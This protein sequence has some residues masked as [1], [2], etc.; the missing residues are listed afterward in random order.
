MLT[1]YHSHGTTVKYPLTSHQNAELCSVNLEP[2][3]IFVCSQTKFMGTG[4]PV[5]P[6]RNLHK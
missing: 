3:Y 2:T 6:H 1:Q 4:K 5:L